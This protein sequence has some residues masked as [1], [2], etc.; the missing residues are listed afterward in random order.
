MIL[1]F[2]DHF[3]RLASM[4]AL[5]WV[6]P[7]TWSDGQIPLQREVSRGAPNAGLCGLIQETAGVP[8]N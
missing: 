8:H 5:L 3:Q 4:Q 7:L 2:G 6:N 1:D